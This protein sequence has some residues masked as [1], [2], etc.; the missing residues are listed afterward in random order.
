MNMQ[1]E[2]ARI[3]GLVSAA[4]ASILALLIAFGVGLSEEQVAAVLGVIAGAGP[5][6]TALVIR[7]KVYAPATVKR[8]V[9]RIADL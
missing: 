4:V 9:K 3:I 6:V 8:I 5:L 7:G 2:P 1:T